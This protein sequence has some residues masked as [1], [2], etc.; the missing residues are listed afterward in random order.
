MKILMLSH[1]ADFGS[2]KVGSHHLAR[3][4][5]LAGHEV[6]HFSTPLSWPQLKLGRAPQNRLWLAKS[7]PVRDKRGVLH[8]VAVVPFPLRIAAQADRVRAA[9]DSV[10]GAAADLVLLDEPLLAPAVS[11]SSPGRLVYRPTDVYKSGVRKARQG[12]LL[13]NV[14]GVVATSEYVLRALQLP[15]GIPS[16]IVENGVELSAF[17]LDI[18]RHPRDGAIY[19]G[20]LDERFDWAA[21]QLMAESRPGVQ[22][23]L[24]G[25]IDRAPRLPANVRI[26][27]ALPYAEVPR[28]LARAKVG[29]LP[30][31]RDA[32]NLGRSPMKFY[33]Y[34]ASGLSVVGTSTPVLERRSAPGVHLYA[35][36]S[37]ML[38]AF[39]RALASPIPNVAGRTAAEAEGWHRKAE[40]LMAHVSDFASHGT[41]SG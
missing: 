10:G 37:Q 16:A 26:Q 1:T 6:I 11:S 4:F 13:K 18:Y 23:D 36:H 9:I 19:V 24:Y 39:D 35:D 32:V 25:P 17:D 29:L 14:D 15:K 28:V 2:F 41:G 31:T 3:E 5:A 38:S 30:F 40:L 7:G 21:V 27:G 22:I 8:V 34:L 12:K 33:E 20:A